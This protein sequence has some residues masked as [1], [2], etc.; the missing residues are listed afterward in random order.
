GSGDYDVLDGN[1]KWVGSFDP[2]Q[3]GDYQSNPEEFL[4]SFVY[5]EA[6]TGDTGGGSGD[7]N[8]NCGGNGKGGPKGKKGT[9][10]NGKPTYNP[11][12]KELPGFPG[13]EKLRNGKGLRQGWRLPN[14]DLAEWDSAH[15]ELEVYDKSGKTHKGAYDP[16]TCQKKKEGEKG[17]KAS[18]AKVDVPI[19]RTNPYRDVN[20]SHT[21]RISSP[22]PSAYATG[23]III[24]MILLIP[25]GI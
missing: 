5:L 14:G 20:G 18:R 3:F 11:A 23:A 12:P 6:S 7:G 13:A 9:G 16:D 8:G 1:G 15:G 22:P 2:S 17:R 4:Q 19:E 21:A 25:I 24:I 10:N